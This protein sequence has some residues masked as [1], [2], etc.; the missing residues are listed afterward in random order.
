VLTL[1]AVGPFSLFFAWRSPL[2]SRRSKWAYTAVI[3]AVT[4]Y[5]AIKVYALWLM[6]SAFFAPMMNPGNIP[7]GNLGI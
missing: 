6:L 4:W 2:L 5:L 3:A 1:F 7:L